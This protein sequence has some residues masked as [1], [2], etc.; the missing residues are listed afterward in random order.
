MRSRGFSTHAGILQEGEKLHPARHEMV[1]LCLDLV[2]AEMAQQQKGLKNSAEVSRL[3]SKLQAAMAHPD[4]RFDASVH[5]MPEEMRRY[6]ALQKSMKTAAKPKPGQTIYKPRESGKTVE[7]ERFEA[8]INADH[9]GYYHWEN[10]R[11]A[12]DV[13]MNHMDDIPKE[14]K[15]KY[16]F[17]W[18]N[19]YVSQHKIQIDGYSEGTEAAVKLGR[20]ETLEEGKRPSIYYFGMVSKF[21]MVQEALDNILKIQEGTRTKNLITA[22]KCVENFLTNRWLRIYHFKSKLRAQDK[23]QLIFGFLDPLHFKDDNIAHWNDWARLCFFMTS[24]GGI[25]LEDM[26]L[27]WQDIG[28]NPPA[29]N[30]SGFNQDKLVLEENGQK[31]EREVSTDAWFSEHDRKIGI[32][33]YARYVQS[34]KREQKLLSTAPYKQ[35]YDELRGMK[36]LG[37]S[38]HMTVSDYT[39]SMR[40]CNRFQINL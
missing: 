7:E 27:W 36:K 30:Y 3:S 5:K 33:N 17:R 12:L 40:V 10:A 21:L 14:K 22:S 19:S 26:A 8:N 13:I 15:A 32:Y 25:I 23:K 39:V 24:L 16:W 35:L 29:T 4:V 38:D 2:K 28:C 18:V 20:K 11:I 34:N 9:E 6:I 37:L 1:R 31:I